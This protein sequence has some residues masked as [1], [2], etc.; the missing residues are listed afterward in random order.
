MIYWATKRAKGKGL[1]CTIGVIDVWIPKYCPVLGL[2]LTPGNHKRHDAS[3]TID[4][5]RPEL[6]YT[7]GNVQVIS[8]RANQLKNNATVAEMERVLRYMRCSGCE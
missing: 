6:G 4:R 8:H 7:P 5:F 2:V 1:P 3:P